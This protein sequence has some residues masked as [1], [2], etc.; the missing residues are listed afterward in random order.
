MLSVMP[1]DDE[2][3]FWV[4][5]VLNTMGRDQISRKGSGRWI[6]VSVGPIPSGCPA[7]VCVFPAWKSPPFPGTCM[8][9]PLPRRQNPDYEQAGLWP[10]ENQAFMA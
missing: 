1:V 2:L 10:N 4:T 3:V 5:A 7:D 8:L 6:A 9:P